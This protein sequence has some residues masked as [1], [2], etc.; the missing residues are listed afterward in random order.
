MRLNSYA[1]ANDILA[2]KPDKVI[3]ATGSRPR[4]DGFNL[5]APG[6][7]I[8]G[9][10][11]PHVLS[12]IDLIMSPPARLGKTALVVDNVGHFEGIMTAIHLIEQGLA[13]T[14]I[15]HHRTFAPYVQTTLRDDSLLELADK[16]DF[17]LLI[18]QV[19]LDI[20][21]NACVIRSRSGKRQQ[22]IAADIVVLVT[23]NEPNR[24]LF[25]QLQGRVPDVSLIGDALSP[26]GMLEAIAEGHRA[27]RAI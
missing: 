19:L 3:I 22:T 18:N 15:T 8:Q 21:K 26:R 16:G 23:S 10:D 12:S 13:V 27:A 5:M 4:M 17:T 7:P 6:D 9:I 1:D 2:E 11:Q 20:G 24:E 25:D 14:Y